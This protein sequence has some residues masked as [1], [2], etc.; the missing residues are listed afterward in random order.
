MA[1]SPKGKVTTSRRPTRKLQAGSAVAPPSAD[2]EDLATSGVLVGPASAPAALRSGLLRWYDAHRRDLPWRFS[3][4]PG[5]EGREK[6][7]YAVWV[8]E[9]ML[10]QT[11]VPVV[12][13]Y[14][15]RWMER[16]PT[17]ET[18][19]AA[20]QEEVNEMWAGLGYYRRAR[21]LLEGAKQIAEKGEFPST[22]STL[23]QVRGIGD[24]TAG[25]IASIA[26]NEVTP[27]VDGN[28]VRVI[29]RLFAI[30]DNPKES[31]TIKRFW[32]LAGQLVDPSRPG[33][34]NQAM[35]ELGAT[36]CSKTKP[37]CSECPVSRHCQALA[38]SQ[39]N[40]S[41]GVTDYPRV[42]PKAKP[43][44]DF[45]AVCV[46]QIAQGLEQEMA[47]GQCNLFLLIKRPE[48]GLLAGLWEF[49]SVLVDESKTDS[50]NRRK[51]MDKYL[52]QLLDIDVKRKYDVVLREDVGQHVHIFSHIRLRM[53]V[54]L[55][56]LK[57]Q[58]DVGQVCN[59]GQDS[60]KL[61]LVDENS[62]DSMGLTSGIRKV[63][64]M[65]KAFKEKKLLEQS[66]I[67]TRKRSRWQKQ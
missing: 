19:A 28:V 4:V 53:H 47:A 66:Q 57:I 23:R 15:S 18:L 50:L 46:V 62:I 36:L 56:V 14:Y 39:E 11:M 41:V 65:V 67:P 59:K 24:Y 25:A 58:G 10:Q 64:N 7:A 31:S 60:M 45:A 51:E 29:S 9:V 35:M 13:D 42:V 16:W 8:S 3:A 38:L 12:I 40:P 55:M 6:R 37:G 61:K 1:K 49:P 43:R 26:F 22:A 52:K 5:R 44:H 21:F 2:I 54:E 30:A 27:L 17:V 33:D 20:T 34:F 32:E 48:E 63:Y